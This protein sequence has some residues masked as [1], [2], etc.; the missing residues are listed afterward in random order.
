VSSGTI[1]RVE[2]FAI[3]DGPGI[4]T[5]VFLKGC[6]LACAWCHSPESQSGA[7]EF[8]PRGDRCIRCGACVGACPHDAIRFT[9]TP[10]LARPEECDLCGSCAEACPSGAR[11]L[12]G[13]RVSVDE[14]LDLI[15]KDRIFYDQSGGGVTFSGGEPL[16]QAA[17]LLD[18]VR[19]CHERG[20]HTAIDTSGFGDRAA[21]LGV[22]DYA[23]LFLFDVKIIDEGR[24]RAHTGAGNGLILDNLG[25]LAARHAAVIVRFPL[26][27]GVNDDDAGV[28]ALGKLVASL[29]LS[30]VDVL[31]YHRAGTAKYHRL[32]RAYGLADVQAPSREA[33]DG[34]ARIL[35]GFGLMVT[36]G[37]SS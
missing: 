6:P 11:E 34:V 15:E 35:E 18:A 31:P 20:I 9:D 32:G 37:G 29:G 25:A 2:R 33:Q 17:F 14:V 22:A 5:T 27:P 24:H 28:A 13:R 7:P 36:R 16:M 8:M 1:F 3:H 19:R 23:D 21:L 26:V 12:V 4:R 30:R 10:A